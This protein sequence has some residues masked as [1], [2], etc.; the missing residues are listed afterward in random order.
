[1]VRD[2]PPDSTP[3]T[4]AESGLWI[5]IGLGNPGPRF[6]SSRHNVGFSCVDVLAARHGISVKERR[7]LAVLGQ[8]A[9][10]GCQV[11]LAKPRT[12]MN[13]SGRAL[14]YMRDRYGVPPERM[15][16]VYDDM[17]LPLGK[18]R[19]RLSG[20]SGGHN[21][22]NSIIGELGTQEFPRLRIGIGRPN[23]PDTI[24]H[25]LGGFTS[26]EKQEIS[27]ALNSAASAVETVLAEGVE[28]AM[29][30]FN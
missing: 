1:V 27:E 17:D 14:R 6:T 8:G 24:A 15:L 20:S 4:A 29:N 18:L 7:Q 3:P 10:G 26:A 11:V 2:G 16:V 21:G 30:G 9:I 22:L 28:R 12:F 25:V 5:V 23:Q 19:L 13:L